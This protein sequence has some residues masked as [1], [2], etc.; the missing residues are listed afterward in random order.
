LAPSGGHSGPD[1][2]YL[3]SS[4][5]TLENRLLRLIRESAEGGIPLDDFVAE[6]SLL[7][8]D[9]RR[10]FRQAEEIRQRRDLHFNAAMKLQEI[11]DHCVW[12]Y[13]KIQLERAFFEKT[14]LESRLRALTSD[15][16]YSTYRRLAEVEELEDR[17]S[18]ATDE[19]VRRLLGQ[20]PP[21]GLPRLEAGS[22]DP[23]GW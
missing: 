11:S 2:T 22:L 15:E 4:V 5:Y 7:A 18:R 6:L 10:L 1:V 8:K 3:S 14:Q 9:L 13:R 12:L 23:D 20:D 17:F 16:A 19:Q 21:D